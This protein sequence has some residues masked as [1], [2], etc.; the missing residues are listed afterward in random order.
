[1]LILKIKTFIK[2]VFFHIYAGLPKATQ[3]E[4]NSRYEI[5][6][7]CDN[8]HSEDS[9]CL[10]CGCNLSNKKQ[11]LNKLAWADQECP[12]NKWQKISRR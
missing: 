9:L 6:I 8:F 2:S 1:M 5:C 11:F 12:A 4:I 10:L 3:S 7:S